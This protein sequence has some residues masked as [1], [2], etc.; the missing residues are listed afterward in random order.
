[1]GIKKKEPADFS[2]NVEVPSKAGSFRFWCQKV[3]PLVYDDSLSYYEL[4]CKVV[5]YLNNVIDDVNTLGT[6]VDNLNKAYIELQSYVNDYFSTLDVQEEINNKLDEMA[7]DG[8]L[9]ELI[10]RF[11]Q[12]IV[13][14]QNK[15]I[16]VLESRMNTFTQ[17]PDGSTSGDSELTDIRVAYN[18]KTYDTAGDSVRAQVDDLHDELNTIEGLTGNLAELSKIRIGKAWNN[19]DNVNRASLYLHVKPNT[20]YSIVTYGFNFDTIFTTEKESEDSNIITGP[21]ATYKSDIRSYF[22]TSEKTNIFVLQFNKPNISIDVFKNFKISFYEG[23]RNYNIFL[24]YK[25]SVD[26]IQ[27]NYSVN[28]KE[29]GA[30]GD[31]TTDDTN[32]FK[33]AIN[34]LI[35]IRKNYTLTADS[36]KNMG[37]GFKLYIPSGIYVL[38]DSVIVPPFEYEYGGSP[39]NMCP[40]TIEGDGLNTSI[41]DFSKC[42]ED[43]NGLE[44]DGG[45]PII[46]NLKI[47]NAKK[48]GLSLKN[49]CWKSR[50]INVFV[51]RSND[52]GFF[53][54]AN[55]FNIV[56]ESCFAY[57]CGKGGFFFSSGITSASIIS[58]YANSCG[59]VGYFFNDNINYTSLISNA[60]DSCGTPY[61]F[62]NYNYI[63]MI[64]NGDE[65]CLGNSIVTSGNDDITINGH[66]SLD[67]AGS[68]IQIRNNNNNIVVNNGRAY[69]RKEDKTIPVILSDDNKT[70]VIIVN[71]LNYSSER[72]KI[73]GNAIL[74]DISN[75]IISNKKLQFNSDKTISW[76]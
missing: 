43:V 67:N 75:G 1:M 51:E 7:E 30:K 59:G 23:E 35:Y 9:Y 40:I 36:S 52:Y 50:I 57:K 12:P 28:V 21:S 61:R 44:V 65:L 2:P 26:Y 13:E 76:S 3:L 47:L 19:D 73:T 62:G 17:L 54:G 10:R 66:F 48:Y 20:T 5:N 74:T 29:Y 37:V 68:L 24:P 31:G 25:T 60:C 41:L 58:N 14:E 42:A 49:R 8:S 6:D 11:T 4:L 18:G 39:L 53:I 64:N 55:S 56:V 63:S 34:E 71:N 22:T 70:N 38:S 46:K 27:R 72:T 45:F 32:A 33:E 69:K 16:D 15:K